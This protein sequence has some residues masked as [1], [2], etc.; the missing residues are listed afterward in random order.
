[1]IG[2]ATIGGVFGFLR[3]NSH[4]A[5]VFMG[6][7]GSQFLGFVLAFLA[8]YL[9]Q[10]VNPA[11]SPALPLLIL[12]LPIADIL[13]VFAQRIYHGMN[14]FKASKNHV[15]H[16]LLEL[17]FRHYESVVIIYS[18]QLLLVASGALLPYETDA[19]LLGMYFAVI[20]ALFIGLYLAER[21]GWRFSHRDSTL[22]DAER[23]AAFLHSGRSEQIVNL[24]LQGLLGVFVLGAALL[25]ER[26][27]VEVSRVALVLLV[28]L[29]VRLLLGY[30]VWFLYLRL[31]L[32]VCVAVFV[33]LFDFLSPDWVSEQSMVW[34]YAY[35]GLLA[36]LL[37]LAMKFVQVERFRLSPLDFL[38][39]I[40]M[41][42]A[43]LFAEQLGLSA[44]T[45]QTVIETVVLFY[46]V[47]W[48]LQH[49][50][51]RWNLF[52]GATLAGLAVTIVR[53]LT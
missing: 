53:G 21:A 32:F 38:V 41:L 45:Q 7:G 26:V 13:A 4:P 22:P 6:D 31:Q 46:A 39:V 15:H 29:L 16:R 14:W 17:G 37:A 50:R 33:Y 27:P 2:V 48:V 1:L 44:D 23:F 24:A 35:F 49:M 5:N 25:S 12:G 9:T 34:V 47:E 51:S 42:V 30:R 3:Y 11:L 36:A 18:V 52:T 20:G 43:A 8:V 40:M 10:E 28:L 19:L